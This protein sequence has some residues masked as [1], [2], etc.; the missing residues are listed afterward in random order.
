MLERIFK[1][2][3]NKTT[4]QTEIMAGVATFLT[5]AYI[6]V[7]ATGG[8]FPAKCSASRRAWISERS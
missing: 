2:S 8:R 4:V 6:V 3:A 7:D 5:M 1:L